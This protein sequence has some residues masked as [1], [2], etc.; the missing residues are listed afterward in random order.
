MRYPLDFF[1]LNEGYTTHPPAIDM[2]APYGTPVKSPMRGTVIAVGYNPSLEG[3]YVI[4]R[5]VSTVQYEHY[6]G[7]NSKVVVK[8]GQVV[9]EGQK[10]AEVG[11]TGLASGPHVHYQIRKKGSG[12][13]VKVKSV[14]KNRLH[15]QPMD[16][17]GKYPL[18]VASKKFD[19]VENAFVGKR[20]EKGKLIDFKDKVIVRGKTYLRTAYDSSTKK[21]TVFVREA[22]DI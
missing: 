12:D 7:H 15:W 10:L 1:V 22:V 5:E 11:A 3:R 13:L 16:H 8:T 6:M 20:Y 4:I 18:R 2:A 14:F 17:P 9:K 21:T 19:L